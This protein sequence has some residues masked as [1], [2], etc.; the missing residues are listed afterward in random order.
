MAPRLPSPTTASDAPASDAAPVAG[1]GSPGSAP[2]FS[3]ARVTVDL[4]FLAFLRRTVEVQR[5]E[6]EGVAVSL[7]RAKDG[8]A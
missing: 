8:A 1:E 3:A 4:G 6:L 2:V 5:L 7:D